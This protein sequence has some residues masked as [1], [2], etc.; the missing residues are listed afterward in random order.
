MRAL[1]LVALLASPA[2]AQDQLVIEFRNQSK[3]PA[4]ISGVFE[5][6]ADGTSIDDN[7][8]SSDIFAPGQTI[9]VPVGLTHC[10]TVEVYAWLGP[11]EGETREE[12]RG[13]TDL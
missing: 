2:M 4:N 8:G 11:I 12:I 1:A 9:R 5:R 13:E 7:L 10:T 3:R 6:R